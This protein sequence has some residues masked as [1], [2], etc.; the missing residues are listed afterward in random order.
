MFAAF[1]FA[2]NTIP[3]KAIYKQN[4]IISHLQECLSVL[5][6]LLAFISG[7]RLQNRFMINLKKIT[8]SYLSFLPVLVRKGKHRKKE[9]RDF[10]NSIL[11]IIV[12]K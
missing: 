4:W 8:C 6:L 10:S 5:L 1:C 2:S 11:Y 3:N 9:I 12:I 7:T